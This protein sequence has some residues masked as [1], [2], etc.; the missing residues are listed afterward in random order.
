MSPAGE[1]VDFMLRNSKLEE[2]KQGGRE[3]EEKEKNTQIQQTTAKRESFSF[4]DE[5]ISIPS[6]EKQTFA[7]KIF[8]GNFI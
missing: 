1:N 6:H 8:H 2:T 5:N 7:V 4:C 3:R